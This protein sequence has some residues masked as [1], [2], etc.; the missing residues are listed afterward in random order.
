[1]RVNRSPAA[2]EPI[3]LRLIGER[4]LV[5]PVTMPVRDVAMLVRAIEG[6]A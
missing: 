6:V 5:L 2:V 4:E 3:R 1:M